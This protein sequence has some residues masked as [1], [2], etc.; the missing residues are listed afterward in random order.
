MKIED[1]KS[2]YIVFNT[3]TKNDEKIVSVDIER[4]MVKTIDHYDFVGEYEEKVF[5]ECSS[6]IEEK[7]KDIECDT[8]RL[9]AIQ[10]RVDGYMWLNT[11]DHYG[12]MH[13]ITVAY[14]P[15]CGKEL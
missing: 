15:T 11:N 13:K 14:C 6:E 2:G 3:V 4:K 10:K 12:N 9:F 1:L 8:C 7:Y 5:V